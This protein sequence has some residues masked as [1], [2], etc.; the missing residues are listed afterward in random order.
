MA[1]AQSRDWYR[2]FSNSRHRVTLH[3]S[4]SYTNS[5]CDGNTICIQQ[6]EKGTVERTSLQNVKHRVC[7]TSALVERKLTISA[8]FPRLLHIA[9]HLP[10]FTSNLLRQNIVRICTNSLHY[11][12][13]SS[14]IRQ[15]QACWSLASDSALSFSAERTV[16]ASVGS[17]Y[18]AAVFCTSLNT[19]QF[20]TVIIDKLKCYHTYTANTHTK[21]QN[22]HKLQTPAC[23]GPW[24]V[25]IRHR[26]KRVPCTCQQ[27]VSTT[28]SVWY[29]KM[30]G[31][32][33]YLFVTVHSSHYKF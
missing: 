21:I 26:R 13:I 8:S 19:F 17:R 5:N 24:L 25:F 2:K 4:T 32:I 3:A 30:Y 18:H 11:C 7:W 6:Q 22:K 31:L 20:N 1:Q 29:L 14:E 10:V 12:I 15:M 33:T 9:A 16:F 23:H 28:S 27:I